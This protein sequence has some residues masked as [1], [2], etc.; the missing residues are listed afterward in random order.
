[1][2]VLPF[3]LIYLSLHVS[4]S[5]ELHQ[6]SHPLHMN[7]TVTQTSSHLLL[8]KSLTLQPSTRASFHTVLTTKTPS[9]VQLQHEIC[10]CLHLQGTLCK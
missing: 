5:D 8:G 9:E 10:F 1:M 3:H 6:I 2:P 4:H 7:T